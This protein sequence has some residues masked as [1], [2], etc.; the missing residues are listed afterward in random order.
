MRLRCST[1]D[2]VPRVSVVVGNHQPSPQIE[3]NTGGIAVW[4]RKG[5]T[6]PRTDEGAAFISQETNKPATLD[7]LNAPWAIWS[8]AASF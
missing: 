8:Y 4:R 7:A 6:F 5:G 2:P 1:L 3:A